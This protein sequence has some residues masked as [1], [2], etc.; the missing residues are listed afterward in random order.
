MSFN[1]HNDCVWKVLIIIPILQLRKVELKVVSDLSSHPARKWGSQDLN[2]VMLNALLFGGQDQ[3]V[4]PDPHCR[5][6]YQDVHKAK[7]I[8]SAPSFCI[9]FRD[10]LPPA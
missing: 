4:E 9:V 5:A 8:S 7:V 10:L 1:P 3:R 2:Y 6:V